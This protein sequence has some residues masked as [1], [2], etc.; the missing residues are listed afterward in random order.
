[1][2]DVFEVPVEIA[3]IFISAF[4]TDLGNIKLVLQQEFASVSNSDFGNKLAIRFSC[5]IFE[6]AAKSRL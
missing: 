5:F 1:M 4:I 3:D 6:I 2:N